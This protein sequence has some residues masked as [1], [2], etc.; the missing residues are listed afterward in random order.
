MKKIV[1]L[2]LMVLFIS[3]CST[4]EPAI[5][6]YRIHTKIPTKEHLLGSCSEKSI[7]VAQAFS[8]NSLMSSK[9]NYAQG[10]TKQFS[11][12]QS[13]WAKTPNIA[14]TQEI[15]KLL[16]STKH[17]KSVQVAKSRSRNSLILEIYIEEF[18]QYFNDDLSKSYANV[19]VGLSLI[20]TTTNNVIA[21][22]S[23]KSQVDAK[24]QNA[25]GG[26]V[27]L[28]NGLENVLVEASSW[29]GDICK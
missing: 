9:I 19:R 29:I 10:S 21:S 17:F 12:S 13:Q 23:F 7:K 20:D 3:G 1:F 4:Q 2:T 24:T 28:N 25:I 26:V 22:N 16:K 5:T 14:I 18:M 11:Y 6:E 15:V 8:I 27:A